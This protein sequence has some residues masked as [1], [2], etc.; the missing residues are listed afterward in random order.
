VPVSKTYQ[1][2]EAPK[3]ILSE[4]TDFQSD[5]DDSEFEEFFDVLGTSLLLETIEVFTYDVVIASVVGLD[6]AEAIIERLLAH[7]NVLGSF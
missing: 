4:L 3:T 2:I 1:A 7:L 6:N 5:L